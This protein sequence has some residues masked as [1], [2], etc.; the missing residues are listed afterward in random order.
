MKIRFNTFFDLISRG[1]VV[2]FMLILSGCWFGGT[3]SG[4]TISVITPD[5]FGI[6]EEIA[7]QLT[8]N[9]R[10]SLGVEKRLLLATVVNLDDLDETTSF[11]RALTEALSTRMFQHGFEVV[12]VRK[13]ADLLVKDD[14]GELMLSRDVKR[15]A[16]Q[17][18]VEAIITGT[19]SLTPNT[20]IVNVRMIEAVSQDVLSVAGIEIQRSNAINN[21]LAGKGGGSSMQLSAYER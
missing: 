6:G 9:L 7:T 2:W 11:G 3:R 20:V 4:G 13:V 21:L 14:G 8:V 17:H 5:F 19:F 16:A 12:E 1:F 10:R 18:S 15:L